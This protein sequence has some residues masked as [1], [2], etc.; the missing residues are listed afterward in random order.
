[1]R[2]RES[3]RPLTCI[4]VE[5]VGPIS[6]TPAGHVL[7]LEANTACTK[8][9]SDTEMVQVLVLEKYF[10]FV[11]SLQLVT[12]YYSGTFQVSPCLTAHVCPIDTARVTNQ[13]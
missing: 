8:Y 7:R 10:Q 2:R 3:I 11:L 6:L 5:E 12:R 9:T 1:M 4:Q 13:S